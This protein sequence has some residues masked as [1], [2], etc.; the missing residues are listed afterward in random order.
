[1]IKLFRNKRVM[2]AAGLTAVV[3]VMW[4]SSGGDAAATADVPLIPVQ[5]GTIHIN[6]L[7]GGEIRALSNYEVKSEIELPTKILSLIPEGYRITE[8]DVKRGKVLIELDSAD[9]KDKITTQEIQFQTTVSAYI[10][11][12]EQRAIQASDNQSLSREAEQNMR[13]ALMDFE[14]YMGKEVAQSVLKARGLPE[15]L[16]SLETHVGKLNAVKPQMTDLK[17]PSQSSKAPPMTDPLAEKQTAPAPEALE[18]AAADTPKKTETADLESEAIGQHIDFLN[19]LTENSLGDGEAQQKLRQLTNES[20]LHQSE[21][22]LAK[23]NFEGSERLAAKEFITKTT[24]ENDRLTLEK[25]R[26]AVQTAETQLDLFKK[27]EFPKQAELNLSAYEEALKK[28]QRTLRANRS[29]MAQAESKFQTAKRRYE[30]ELERQEDLERQYAAAV[31][32]APVPGLVAYGMR[33]G[34]SSFRNA[35]AIEEG[36]GVRFRQTLL[37]I[38]DMA[39]MGVGVSI[40]ESQVKKVRLGQPCRVTVDAEPGKTLDGVVAELAVLPDSTSSRYTPNLKVYPAVIHIAGVHDWLKPG[41]NAK[42]EIIVDQLEDILYV[43]VQSIEVEN[44]HFFTY[45]K[46]GGI[47]TRREVKTGSFN[48]EFIEI[49]SGVSLGEQIALSI[50]KRLNLESNPEPLPTSTTPKKTKEKGPEVAKKGLAA[51]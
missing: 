11:A 29:R 13:F 36:A 48:D 15:D 27:Y 51:K 32:K 9:I 4:M 8:E 12:D 33:S 2:I 28:L 1:M 43:P 30:V 3:L 18:K 21:L 25:T 26:L 49:M 19:Y 22:A 5:K 31:I 39:K 50:P 40:H 44:D 20:L 47:L 14:R 34:G 46:D 37:T 35:D 23:R 6:V 10:E 17:M 41:M 24:L 16:R 38:P 42:V 7:Q 45:V